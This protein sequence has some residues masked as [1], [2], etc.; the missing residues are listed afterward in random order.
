MATKSEKKN[1]IRQ[2]IIEAAAIYS[3]NLAGKIFLYV[4][5]DEF[6]ELFFLVDSFLHLTGVGTTLSAKEFYKNAKK[7]K[8]TDRQF[9]FDSKHLFSNAKKKLPCLRRLP[10]LTTDRV[11]ILKDTQTATVTYKL[12]VTNLEFT[13]CLT[14][15]TD[16]NGN[17]KNDLFLPMSLRVKDKSVEKSR[18]GAIVDY[19]FSKDASVTKYNRLLVG[20]KSES[21]PD[22]VKYLIKFT[23]E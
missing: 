5:G 6:F 14:N 17:K 9:Y 15:N 3:Q 23:E 16:K 18:D 20:D 8:I 1:E 4:Y 13:L 2:S 7:A 21:I 10:E 12:S 19:I 22:G 11:C